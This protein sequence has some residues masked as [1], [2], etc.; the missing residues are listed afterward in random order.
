MSSLQQHA[1]AANDNQVRDLSEK[2]VQCESCRTFIP[3]DQAF[4]SAKRFYCSAE[5]AKL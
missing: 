5:H 4:I 2:L 3:Q 1:H